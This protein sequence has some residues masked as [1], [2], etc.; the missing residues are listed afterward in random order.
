MSEHEEDVA[1][2][3]DLDDED[4]AEVVVTAFR[5]EEDW[6]LLLDPGVIDRTVSILEELQIQAQQ[7]QDDLHELVHSLGDG[8]KRT[9]AKQALG[10]A[11]S[12][13]KTVDVR[14]GMARRAQR[15]INQNRNAALLAEKQER[16][17]ARLPQLEQECEETRE[18]V[19]LL[20]L[21]IQRHRLDAVGDELS[22]EPG[23][24][25]LWAVLDEVA[26][27][28]GTGSSTLTEMLARGSW[29]EGR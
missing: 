11:T 21:A 17:V 7:K 16:R 29:T 4:F 22:P 3:L 5:V 6:Q 24:R 25:R 23:D 9:R 10:K 20:T 15:A 18:A 26:I 2:L 1:A 28:Y 19:R 27:P 8:W 13:R 14:K 12:H